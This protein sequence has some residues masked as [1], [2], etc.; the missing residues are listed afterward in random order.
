MFF[1]FFLL[2]FRGSNCCGIKKIPNLFTKKI[3]ILELKH[4]IENGDIVDW[5]NMEKVFLSLFVF[6]HE[7][8]NS[9][10]LYLLNFFPLF[11]F[12]LSSL[13]FLLKQLWIHFFHDIVQKKQEETRVVLVL[14]N[15]TNPETEKIQKERISHIFFEKFKVPSLSILSS[16]VCLVSFSTSSSQGTGMVVEVGESV[17]SVSSVFDGVLL[18][19][20]CVTVP[21][22]GRDVTNCLKKFLEIG[23]KSFE[24]SE[25]YQIV[26]DIKVFFC[27]SDF[28]FS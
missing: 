12:F 27:F 28:F 6:S 25:Q 24:N 16:P 18:P 17:M 5:E 8:S 20:C 4:P 26:K 10:R 9:L 19:Q 23:G 14:T 22:G 1:L 21:F 13:P 3:G 2:H 15:H 11:F 7:S